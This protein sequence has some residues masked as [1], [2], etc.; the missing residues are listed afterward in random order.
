MNFAL[1]T[2]IAASWR[3][4]IT[5]PVHNPP[6]K[7]GDLIIFLEATQHGTLPSRK[8]IR[9]PA[10]AGGLWT[11]GVIDVRQDAAI[12]G[13]KAKFILWL[14]FISGNNNNRLM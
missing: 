9:S 2:E 8:I 7:A 6:A 3:T 5:P 14:K 10:F 13:G 4:S 11:G 1:P 12:S